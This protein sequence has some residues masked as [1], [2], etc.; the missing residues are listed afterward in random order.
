MTGRQCKY[1]DVIKTL[2]G[3]KWICNKNNKICRC[4]TRLNC[5]SFE[6]TSDAKIRLKALVDKYES[7]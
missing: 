1:C 3:T 4:R 2:S 6:A 7:K 5:L